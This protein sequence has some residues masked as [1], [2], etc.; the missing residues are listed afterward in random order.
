MFFTAGV[1]KVQWVRLEEK[2]DIE[3]GDFF[4]KK[5]NKTKTTKQLALKSTL[6]L[7][8][9]EL[10]VCVQYTLEEIQL[11]SQWTD[12]SV[13]MIQRMH[14]DTLDNPPHWVCTSA[15]VLVCL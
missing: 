10:H 15:F 12:A 3:G 1:L 5:L 6:K 2:G 4:F 11:P 13:I 9:S 8:I 14:R 7:V